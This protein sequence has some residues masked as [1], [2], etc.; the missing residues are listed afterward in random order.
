MNSLLS[1]KAAAPSLFLVLA[2]VFA[3]LGFHMFSI[4]QNW[5]ITIWWLDIV[6]H[7]VGGAWVVFAF[8]YVQRRYTLLFSALPFVF[9]LV[10]VMGI[11]MLVGVAWEWFEFGFDYFF[12]PEAALWRAQLGLTDTMGDLLADL[13]GGTLAGFY[14]LLR[15]RNVV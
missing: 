11:V 1:D 10:M 7:M 5:Y 13:M 12:V 6:L 14:F 9:S 2:V 3:I 8:F 4:F 15:R